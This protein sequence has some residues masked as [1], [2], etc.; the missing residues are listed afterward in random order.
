MSSSSGHAHRIDARTRLVSS[1]PQFADWLKEALTFPPA[2]VL[3]DVETTGLATHRDKLVLVQV[4]LADADGRYQSGVLIDW[5]ARNEL[6]VFHPGDPLS[7]QS[8]FWELLNPLLRVPGVPVVGHNITFDLTVL[9][10]HGFAIPPLIFD[11][12]VAEQVLTGGLAEEEGA[13]KGYGLAATVARR[14]GD[15]VDPLSKAERDYFIGLD[16]RPDAWEGPLPDA[17]LRYAARDI[18]VLAPLWHA[19]ATRLAELGLDEV[20]AI[21]MGAAPAVVALQHGGVVVDVEAWGEVICEQQRLADELEEQVLSDFGPALL[22]ARQRAFDAL[23]PAYNAWA[24]EHVALVEALKVTWEA[25]PVDA[26]PTWPTYK[27]DGEAAWLVEHPAP[28]EP[29]CDTRL[30]NFGSVQQLAQALAEL[31]LVTEKTGEKDLTAMRDRLS[32]DDPR[33]E[34][35]THLLGCRGAKKLVSTYGD[36]LLA[37]QGH[38]GR[39]HPTYRLIGAETG[40]MSSRDP[41]WQNIPRREVGMQLRQAVVASP[42]C[43]L[44]TAD[45]S[46]IEMW[47]LA[48]ISGDERML[49]ALGSGRDLHTETARAMFGLDATWDKAKASRTVWRSGRSY[50]DAGKGLNFRLNYGGGAYGLAQELGIGVDEAQEL[51]DRYFAAFPRVAAWMQERREEVHDVPFSVTVMGRI[52]RY[53]LPPHCAFP[54]YEEEWESKRRWRSI[55]RQAL[56]SPIQG[57]SADIT[58]LALGNLYQGIVARN[59]THTWRL[60]TVVHDEFV[61]EVPSA[62]V[63]EASAFLSQT[64]QEAAL[65]VL[66]RIRP[67]LEMPAPKAT[68]STS[69]EK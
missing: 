28:P 51:M 12:M 7:Y 19:Q 40:R 66:R 47:C 27:R 32:A 3:L 52:R 24:A 21:E 59:K 56:N 25:L 10:A 13:D 38:D 37:K 30:P 44:L 14:F 15:D 43:M 64:M 63:E 69:W 62:D 67:D 1:P 35:I 5:R 2:A 68:A 60:V 4:G 26:R 50:R 57:T 45:Y 11:T 36:S 39:L 54:T 16:Q 53:A 8:E 23:A 41:N 58:K 9:A 18:A 46:N 48:A 17:Q 42:G 22:A 33:R 49:E 20:M 34:A 29:P 31:G 6:T 65:S 61:L 55:E